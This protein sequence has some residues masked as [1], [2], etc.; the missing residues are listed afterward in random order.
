MTLATKCPRHF[1][2]QCLGLF[3]HV[4]SGEAV[5]VL[6]LSAKS[7]G[8]RLMLESYRCRR[9][10]VTLTVMLPFWVSAFLSEN[11]GKGKGVGF[12]KSALIRS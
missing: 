8:K 4:Q 6:K 1:M 9:L 12:D 11:T 7:E 3:F 5:Q 2:P 10:C